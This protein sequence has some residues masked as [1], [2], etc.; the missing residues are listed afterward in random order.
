MAWIAALISAGVGLYSA[1]QQKKAGQKVGRQQDRLYGIQADTAEALQPYS[2]KFYQSAWDTYNPARAY[3]EA[4]ASNDRGKILGA[5]SPQLSAIGQRYRSIRDA[6]GAL[7]PRGGGSA[8]FNAELAYREGDEKQA[9]INAE[10]SGA[11]GN[12][13][14]LSGL[15][16]DLGAGVAGISTN[17]AAGA[18]G[19][20][21]NAFWM[22]QQNAAG[23]AKAY[24]EVGEA[25]AGLVGYD[26]SKGWYVGSRPGKG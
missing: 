10:R 3:Y 11:Y 7:Q 22:Q 21:S 4:I 17:A 2:S 12:L 8:A 19:L 26:P 9:L 6:Q 24:G 5:L 15:A 20:L 25:L 23:Q 13:G 18:S 1:N 16:G 14:K